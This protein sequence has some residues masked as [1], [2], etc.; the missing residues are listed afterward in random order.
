MPSTSV[1]ELWKFHTEA[2]GDT[3]VRA[4]LGSESS[5]YC[6]STFIGL[7]HRESRDSAGQ[8]ERRPPSRLDWISPHLYSE[9]SESSRD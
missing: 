6:R 7:S 5:T 8:H 4:N 1:V 3:A 2:F 9:R